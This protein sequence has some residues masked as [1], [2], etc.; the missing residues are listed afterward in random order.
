MSSA[1]EAAVGALFRPAGHAL[2]IV[3]VGAAEP[4][5][6]ALLERALEAEG[7]SPARRL[8]RLRP[9]AGE[10]DV[11]AEDACFFLERY[12]H[13]YALAWIAPPGKGDQLGFLVEVAARARAEGAKVVVDTTGTDIA[14]AAVSPGCDLVASGGRVVDV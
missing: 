5:A 2:G 6:L 9:R 3:V 13:E 8:A 1:L 12:G 10:P 4:P 14:A 7:L 11:R